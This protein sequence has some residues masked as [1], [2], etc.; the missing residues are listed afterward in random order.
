MSSRSTVFLV[1]GLTGTQLR[2]CISGRLLWLNPELM[3][4]CP[5]SLMEYLDLHYDTRTKSFTSIRGVA[6]G[7]DVGDLKSIKMITEPAMCSGGQFDQFVRF[8]VAIGG[9]TE[10][11]DLF[12]VPYDWRLILDPTYWGML[13]SALK[14]SIERHTGGCSNTRA[15]LIGFSL[16]GIIITRFL[17]EQDVEWRHRFIKRVIFAAVPIG[18]SPKAFISVCG[19][20]DELPGYNTPCVRRFLQR[21]SGAFLCHPI[22]ACFP[23][24]KIIE[25]LKDDDSCDVISFGVDQLKQA[26]SHRKYR[27]P[28]VLEIYTDY[29]DM[30]NGLMTEGIAD[31]VEL[32][33]VYSSVRDT[34]IALDYRGG[35][36][37][38][39]VRETEYYQ[40]VRDELRLKIEEGKI[41]KPKRRRS[42]RDDDCLEKLPLC[43]EPFIVG[44]GI[45]PFVSL[46]F[47]DN[48]KYPDGRPFVTTTKLFTGYQYEHSELFNRTA[49]IQHVYDLLEVSCLDHRLEPLNIGLNADARPLRGDEI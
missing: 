45:V 21:C 7:G 9:Y 10:D 30:I 14:V 22:P 31:D 19:N 37:G 27:N 13:S 2:D 25:N 39:K 16:G 24:L 12:G 40:Q 28:S 43:E 47:W 4:D 36:H 20:T 26:Y 23:G 29:G 41:V 33:V 8:L 38:H 48:K 6:T 42:R 18:G 5:A 35:S 15:T 1:P 11:K 32:H 49:V 44:D 46:A 34:T 17:R 3:L